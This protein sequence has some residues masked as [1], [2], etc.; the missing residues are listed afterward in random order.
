LES[1]FWLWS[2]ADPLRRPLFARQS[3]DDITISDRH[4]ISVK[5]PLTADGDAARAVEQLLTLPAQGIKVRTR[6]LTTTL[7]ARLMLSDLFLHGIG[8]AKYDQVTDSIARQFFGFELPRFAAVSATLRLPIAHA[9][10]NQTEDR[11]L[12]RQLRELRY[13]PERFAIGGRLSANHSPDV[14]QIVTTKRRWVQTKKTPENAHERHVAITSA[15]EALQPHVNELLRD[16]EQQREQLA[17][18]KRANAILDSREYSF[19]LY[20]RQHFEPLLL[21]DPPLTP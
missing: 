9:A 13:H 8:G 19:C 14:Q 2:A 1:P 20:P 3:A 16:V 7:F 15:N 5:L 6:A 17:R 21:D 18:R 12:A 10:T 11:E 4:A